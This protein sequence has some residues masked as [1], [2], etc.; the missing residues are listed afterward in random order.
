MMVSLDLFRFRVEQKQT[1]SFGSYPYTGR[2][3]LQNGLNLF[4][5]RYRSNLFQFLLRNGIA[6]KPVDRGTDIDNIP[7]SVKSWSYKLVHSGTKRIINESWFFNIEHSQTFLCAYKQLFRWDFCNTIDLLPFAF[8]L[9]EEIS[10]FVF[11]FVIIWQTIPRTDPD[12]SLTVSFYDSWNV[13]SNTVRILFIMLINCK[14]IPVILVYSIIGREPH[15]TSL[16]LI[17]RK[18]GALWQSFV[19]R[20]IREV[21]LLRN[22]RKNAINPYT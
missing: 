16:V 6:V 12:T 5:F 13:I 21:N 14:W 20:N 11:F 10:E 17:D 18:Y 3:L 19:N 8:F 22:F 4:C 15:I 7:L 2:R 9:V 1:G